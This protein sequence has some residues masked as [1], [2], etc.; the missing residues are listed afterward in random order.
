LNSA[1]AE[2][3][4]GYD[5]GGVVGL[6]CSAFTPGDYECDF[7]TTNGSNLRIYVYVN[8]DGSYTWELGG[9]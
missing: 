6:N 9:G 3:A 7:S 8:G 4:A 2:A 5:G 1:A